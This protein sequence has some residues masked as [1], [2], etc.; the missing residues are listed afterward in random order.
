MS[1][2]RLRISNSVNFDDSTVTKIQHTGSTTDADLGTVAVTG[3]GTQS[4]YETDE[5]GR[6]SEGPGLE[7][8][9]RGFVLEKAPARVPAFAHPREHGVMQK[10]KKPTAIE[11]AFTTYTLTD[12]LGEGG[13]GRVYGGTGPDGPVAVKVLCSV[14]SD[15]RRR[16]KNE[17]AFLMRNRHLNIVTVTD[18]GVASNGTIEGPFYVMRR[19]DSHLRELMRA[20]IAPEDALSIFSKILDGVEAAHMQ[21]VTHRDLKPENI[22]LDRKTPAI[23][24]FGVA[25]FTADLIVTSVE[26]LPA[27]RLANFQYAAPEQRVAGRPVGQTAD[28]YALGMI[29]NE[30]ITGHAPHG[31]E[32]AR[33]GAKHP[34]YE[35]VDR[36]VAQCLRQESTERPR[37][38][39]ELRALLAKYHTEFQTEQRLGMLK[40]TVV[41][42]GEIDDP[43][44][45][46]PPKLVAADWDN[47]TLTLTLDRPVH[48][49]WIDGLN[50]V[51]NF[52]SLVG[53]EPHRFQFS[54]NTARVNVQGSA[55]QMTIDYFKD[56]L[57]KATQTY[58]QRLQALHHQQMVERQEKLNRERRAEQERL[59]VISGLRV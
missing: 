31:T 54:G 6:L 19:Y 17:I 52:T 22:L 53:L 11:T 8:R 47:N 33:I 20:P 40:D 1:V 29:L 15:K 21:G 39:G 43:L 3:S 25:S 14:S 55:A 59:K 24:D 10:L 42:A 16:F 12:I 51:G 4:S 38:V 9:A 7:K 48:K 36:A 46:E 18:Y 45:L 44:A 23:A 30:M 34:Q 13:A 32:Y 58:K 28:L 2:S 37:S 27:Q 41:K 35:Y 57:P 50:N 26:T 49:A 5:G 56:W